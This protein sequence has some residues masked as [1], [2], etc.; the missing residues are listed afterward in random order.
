M[1]RV[2]IADDHPII[3]SGAEA[4]L[5]GSRF[6]VVAKLPDGAAVLAALDEV[7][8]DILILD[9]QMPGCSGLDVLRILRA[10]ADARPV[11]L[12]TAHIDNASAAE[13]IALGVNG[14]VLKDTAPE[15]LLT[16]LEAVSDGGRWIDEDV[17]QR[18]ADLDAAS[19]ADRSRLNALTPRERA[20][21]EL[22]VQGMRNREVASALGIAEGT[23]KLH[24]YKVYE[25]LGV[26]SRT[27][28]VIHAQ[29]LLQR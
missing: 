27:E 7:A 8:P 22:V 2:M 18:A 16:C 23:V 26:S 28:L 21:A 12:L 24:L 17:L 4:L 15:T 10:R 1:I 14:L 29:D 11:I 6:E 20:V 25:K 13:A 3:L 19:D 5:R 9:V